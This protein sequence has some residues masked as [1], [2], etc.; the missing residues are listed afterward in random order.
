MLKIK[1]GSFKSLDSVTD[2][3]ESKQIVDDG[4]DVL[5]IVKVLSVKQ[6]TIPDPK[7]STSCYVLRDILLHIP[8][9]IKRYATRESPTMKIHQSEA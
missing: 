8:I 4:Y 3:A 5:V 7:F 6:V 9:K 1:I 2:G